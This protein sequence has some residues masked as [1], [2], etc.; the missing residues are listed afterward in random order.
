MFRRRGT[1][2]LTL[3]FFL[4]FAA[5]CSGKTTI[6][7]DTDPA[8]EG[9]VR[10]DEPLEIIGYTTN[11]QVYHQWRGTVQG[12]G[13]DSL[14]FKSVTRATN[15]PGPVLE[16][17]LQVARESVQSFTFADFHSGRT[18]LVVFVCSTV[19]LAVVWASTVDYGMDFSSYEGG[20]AY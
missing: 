11:E 16:E 20:G 3:C 13:A 17:E 14:L 9:Q 15:R 5:G 12:A 10:L 1:R 19:L 8:S 18:T 7:L 2:V 6:P 4:P